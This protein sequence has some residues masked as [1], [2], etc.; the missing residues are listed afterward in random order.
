MAFEHRH[1]GDVAV[2]ALRI[3]TWR[4]ISSTSGD[5]SWHGAKALRVPDAVTLVPLWPYSPEVNLVE[6]IW[7]YRRERF[8]LSRIP[9]R[10]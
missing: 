7:L 8:L 2:E 4:R 1:R 6:R 3:S 10:L 9:L 5:S